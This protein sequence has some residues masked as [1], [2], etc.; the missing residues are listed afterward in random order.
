[1]ILNLKII[2][3]FSNMILSDKIFRGSY[4]QVNIVGG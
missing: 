1:M 3:N 2:N 4:D